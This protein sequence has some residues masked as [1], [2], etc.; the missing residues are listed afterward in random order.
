MVVADD[1]REID[2]GSRGCCNAKTS[3]TAYL[4]VRKDTRAMDDHAVESDARAMRDQDV[5]S[6]AVNVLEVIKAGRS[7][8]AAYRRLSGCEQS[9]EK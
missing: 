7:Q 3:P 6:F 1:P 9:R 8:M 4:T 2:D 5:R